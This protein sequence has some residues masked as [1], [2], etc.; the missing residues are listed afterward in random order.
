[1]GKAPAL[2]RSQRRGENKCVP[3]S[4]R[5]FREKEQVKQGQQDEVRLVGMISVASGSSGCPWFSGPW[6]WVIRAGGE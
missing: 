5:S 2:V 6:P 4:F 3:E 1:M